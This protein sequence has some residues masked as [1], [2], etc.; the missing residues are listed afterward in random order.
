M[1]T[2]ILIGPNENLIETIVDNLRMDGRNFSDRAIVFPGKR[3]A[4]FLRKEL[5][6][7]IG[8]SFIPPCILSVDD[9]VLTLF[10]QLHPEAT[11][12]LEPI[13]A[14]TLLYQIHS[15]L[16]ER[17]GGDYFSSLDTFVPIGL[18]LFDELEELRLA[19]L[20]ERRLKETL[21]S[22]TYNRLFRLQSTIHDSIN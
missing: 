18:K 4:H 9:F 11:N 15:E 6:Q 13:D 12:D 22:L 1:S 5:A 20:P 21:S 16:K 8:G 17:L 3:P 7:R 14:I 19:N 10:R 2:R